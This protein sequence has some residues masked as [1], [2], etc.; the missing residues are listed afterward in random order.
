MSKIN[1]IQPPKKIFLEKKAFFPDEAESEIK[2][3]IDEA[4]QQDL[5]KPEKYQNE[6]Q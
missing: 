2:K 1:G 3:Y 4:C 6:A 5:K